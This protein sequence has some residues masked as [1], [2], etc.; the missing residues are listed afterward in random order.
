MAPIYIHATRE[1]Q[2]Q[3]LRADS[4]GSVLS[5]ES[6]LRRQTTDEASPF[7]SWRREYECARAVADRAGPWGSG[8]PRT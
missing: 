1:S 5:G 8:Q 7:V 3:L 2:G 6:D 4:A